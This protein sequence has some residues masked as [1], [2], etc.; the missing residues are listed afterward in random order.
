MKELNNEL[1][2]EISAYT[3]L[4]V[5]DIEKL[6]IKE[7]EKK[8]GIKATNPH[9]SNYSPWEIYG[10]RGYMWLNKRFVGESEL[11]RREEKV[12]KELSRQGY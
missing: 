10:G 4:G 3:K 12:T 1:L 2:E 6:G 9:K 11:K 5:G 7:I 8:L